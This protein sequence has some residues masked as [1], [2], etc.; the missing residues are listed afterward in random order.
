M[1]T[2]IIPRLS[3]KE[4]ILI[5]RCRLFLQVECISDISNAEGTKIR[6]EWLHGNLPKDAHSKKTGRYKGTLAKKHGA[7]GNNLLRD[8]SR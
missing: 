3:R 8:N 2:D 4:Q 1:D 5:N 7:F 6:P